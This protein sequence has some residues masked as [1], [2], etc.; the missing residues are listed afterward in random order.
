MTVCGHQSLQPLT[1]SVPR[2]QSFISVYRV[3]PGIC[4]FLVYLFDFSGLKKDVV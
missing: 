2:Y 3:W 4:G 1:P